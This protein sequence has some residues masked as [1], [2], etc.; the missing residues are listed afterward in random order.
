MYLSS[1]VYNSAML[2]LF[3]RLPR[4]L[5]TE[6]ALAY[7]LILALRETKEFGL[8]EKALAAVEKSRANLVQYAKDLSMFMSE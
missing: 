8:V 1:E 7:G 2:P 3:S 5:P 6:L 4:N